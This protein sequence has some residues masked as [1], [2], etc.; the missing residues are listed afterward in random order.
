MRVK[1]ILENLLQAFFWCRIHV[2]GESGRHLTGRALKLDHLPTGLH[3]SRWTICASDVTL[4][5][6]WALW[7]YRLG[8]KQGDHDQGGVFST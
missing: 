6:A 2:I 8:Q 4:I 3:Y 7:K 1:Y 5:P